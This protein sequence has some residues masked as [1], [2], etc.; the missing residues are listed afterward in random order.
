MPEPELDNILTER[1][2]TWLTWT[3]DANGSPAR[4]TASVVL[5]GRYQ[6]TGEDHVDHERTGGAQSTKTSIKDGLTWEEAEVAALDGHGWR[7]SVAKC[8]HMDAE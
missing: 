1:L 5:T 6:D 7:R 8:V 2:T 4:T 3:R